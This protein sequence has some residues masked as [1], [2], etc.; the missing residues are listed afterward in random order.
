[1]IPVGIS[2]ATGITIGGKLG[3]NKPEVAKR[4]AWFSSQIS[5]IWCAIIIALINLF[6]TPLFSFF[7][8]DPAIFERIG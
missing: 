2:A 1:M 4:K 6:Y 8:N 7:T 3:A 5:F